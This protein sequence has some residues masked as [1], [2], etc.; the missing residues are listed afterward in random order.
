MD[1][2]VDQ[3]SNAKLTKSSKVDMELRNNPG[4]VYVKILMTIFLF[5]IHL[6]LMFFNSNRQ[7]DFNCK[8]T[9][10]IKPYKVHG[11]LKIYC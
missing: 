6:K 10:S 3:S 7:S 9:Q 11:D 5:L 1:S 2:F 4:L 8:F